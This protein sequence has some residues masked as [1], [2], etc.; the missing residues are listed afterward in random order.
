MSLLRAGPTRLATHA[1]KSS[2]IQARFEATSAFNAAAVTQKPQTEVAPIPV[3]KDIVTAD[4]VSGA[5]SAL[6]M[7]SNGRGNRR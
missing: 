2:T 4:V 1:L 6:S 5:P 7:L 3:P